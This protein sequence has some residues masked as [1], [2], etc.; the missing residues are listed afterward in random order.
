MKVGSLV[1]TMCGR[2]GIVESIDDRW[3][4][5]NNPNSY[6]YHVYMLDDNWRVEFF[7]EEHL[8]LKEEGDWAVLRKYSGFEFYLKA[9]D[10]LYLKVGDL[11]RDI[12]T[13]ELHFITSMGYWS[14]YF[15]V[16]NVETG[17]TTE[18]PEEHL[19][20]ISASR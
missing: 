8:E 15:V 16:V 2:L 5:F 4:G 14:G 12:F 11:V 17:V 18:E 10:E 20:V 13:G 9:I 3:D 19:E 6:P 1:L 7:K